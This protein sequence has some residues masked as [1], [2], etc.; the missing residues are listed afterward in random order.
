MSQ[1]NSIKFVFSILSEFI[2]YKI[3]GDM[4]L[5]TDPNNFIGKNIKDVLPENVASITTK[6]IDECVLTRNNQEYDYELGDQN[7][8]SVLTYNSTLEQVT[9]IITRK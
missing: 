6:M 5:Y 2:S 7:F 3:N 9:A 4:T 1:E 8:H